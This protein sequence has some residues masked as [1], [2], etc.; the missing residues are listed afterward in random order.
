[1]KR[2]RKQP[3]QTVKKTTVSMTGTLSLPLCIG[4]SAWIRT[5]HQLFTTSMVVKILEVAED[6]IKF[7]TCNTI[8]HLKYT[9][10]SAESGVLCA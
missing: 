5:S 3:L 9:S 10:I 4:E 2:H 8:Y 6:S 1:M 7:E